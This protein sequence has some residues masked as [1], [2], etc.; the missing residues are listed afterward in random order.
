M[1]ITYTWSRRDIESGAAFEVHGV[2]RVIAIFDE[3]IYVVNLNA[4]V[5]AKV[6]LGAG[7]PV[8][9][10]TYAEHL[11]EVQAKPVKLVF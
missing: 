6:K 7:I 9:R 4:G 10:E 5:T 11:T 2:T 8:N 1:K 3:A